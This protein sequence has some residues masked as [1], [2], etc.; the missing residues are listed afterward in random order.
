[1]S[2]VPLEDSATKKMELP[3][4]Y[5]IPDEL[6]ARWQALAADQQFVPAL[7]R[8]AWDRLYQAVEQANTASF[9]SIGLVFKLINSVHDNKPEVADQALAE[10]TA[11]HIRT[12]NALRQFQEMIMNVA[13]SETENGVEDGR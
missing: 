6:I 9:A 3:D 2:D 1:M 11:Q 4:E 5:D 8:L 10:F 13:V 12:R 7:P